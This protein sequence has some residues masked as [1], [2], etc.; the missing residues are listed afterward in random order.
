MHKVFDLHHVLVGRILLI[1]LTVVVV[2]ADVP[3]S[4]GLLEALVAGECTAFSVYN[5]RRVEYLC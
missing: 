4:D 2:V 1:D 3:S 5:K